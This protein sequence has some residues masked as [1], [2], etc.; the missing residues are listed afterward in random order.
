MYSKHFANVGIA[1]QK[2]VHCFHHVYNLLMIN[3]KKKKFSGKDECLN[4]S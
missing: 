1:H 4:F 2:Y 3:K